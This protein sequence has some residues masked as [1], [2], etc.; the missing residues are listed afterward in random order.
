[1]DDVDCSVPSFLRSPTNLRAYGADDDKA[2]P[3]ISVLYS[4]RVT[5]TN[6]YWVTSDERR[7][8]QTYIEQRGHPR[9]RARH[10][11]FSINQTARD[12]WMHL[13]NSALGEAAL[14]EK[15]EQVLR[16]FFN[17]MSTFMINQSESATR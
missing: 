11:P 17:E 5:L 12:R 13:M 14:P 7:R 8:P 16:K 2:H 4:V 10:S 15:A 6:H 3:A 9:L 1:M